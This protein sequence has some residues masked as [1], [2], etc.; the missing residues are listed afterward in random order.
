MKFRKTLFLSLLIGGMTI[1]SAGVK[2]V[3]NVSDS[4]VNLKDSATQQL[5]TTTGSIF[6]SA[7]ISSV[8]AE[9]E[10]VNNPAS[11]KNNEAST[12]SSDSSDQPIE[13]PQ[14]GESDYG[15]YTVPQ[16]RS[17]LGGVQHRQARTA[18]SIPSVVA[19][20]NNTPSKSFVD[21]SSH[22]GTLS[23]NDFLNMKKYGV[24]GVVVKLTEYTTYINKEAAL[25]IK[26]AK[27]AGLKVS[28]YHYS[29]FK[30]DDQAR[31]EADYFANAARSF[32]LDNSTIMVNDIEEPTIHGKGNHTA[33]SIAFENRLKQL[34]FQNVRHYSSYSWFSSG[35][36]NQQALDQKKIWVAA[37][38]LTIPNKNLYTQYGSWQWNSRLRFPEI[39]NKE[40]DISADYTGS[41]TQPNSNNALLSYSSHVENIGWMNSVSDNSISGTVGEAKRVEA[42]TL[43]LTNKVSGNIEYRSHLAGVG[44]ET[45]WKKNGEISGTTGQ[46][47]RVEA[48]Q[49]KLSGE[50]ANKYDVYYRAHSENF[51][52]LNWARNG[53]SAGSEGFG[54]RL[55]AIQIQLVPKGQAAPTGQ[56]KKF[57]KY[58]NANIQYQTDVQGEGWTT[59]VGDNQV[60]GTVGRKLRIEAVKIKLTN[61]PLAFSGNIEYQ[62]HI[63]G[64]G[65]QNWKSNYGLSGTE[66]RG[67]RT[68]AIRIRLTGELA[69]HYY[70]Y[71]RVHSESYGW[72]GWTKNGAI[73]GTTGKSKRMEAIQVLL[74]R[75]NGVG[76]VTISRASIN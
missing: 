55:E 42:L 45:S 72:L 76:P 51:G 13:L 11:T 27:A 49:V 25:Q 2:A 31:T 18:S 63:Q 17:D 68:E 66:G 14:F 50:A 54:Y 29:W 53:E 33:N 39:A 7:T 16:N 20:N 58:Q 3:E 22:N 71:Y 44:W 10:P 5:E 15:T 24:T 74:V 19:T 57:I 12:E 60:S 41:F 64:I 9:S 34:G 38:P 1:F 8:T 75:K 61:N 23:V 37:Y 26:N 47:R 67:L 70:V 48:L 6:G 56:G 65:W 73:A 40:F 52:W 62:T 32:G 21:I 4:S 43:S 35:S 46:K 30:T 69:M 28:A 36:L 59:V